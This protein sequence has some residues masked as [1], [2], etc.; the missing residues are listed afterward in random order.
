MPIHRAVSGYARANAVSSGWSVL[1]CSLY[2]NVHLRRQIR[3]V[4]EIGVVLTAPLSAVSQP[5]ATLRV[6]LQPHMLI[7]LGE[8]P[9]R[10]GDVS[11]EDMG[12]EMADDALIPLR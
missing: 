8:E 6:K 9:R 7:I 11:L 12:L 4:C 10:A 1:Y 3:A 2:N 5:R